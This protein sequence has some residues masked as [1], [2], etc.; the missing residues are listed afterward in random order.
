[1]TTKA[2]TKKK[3]TKTKPKTV[4]IVYSCG[5][6]CKAKAKHQH[7]HH[8]DTVILKAT[9]TSVDITFT[10]GSPFSA[11]TV[12]IAK[13]TTKSETVSGA[14]GTYPYTLACDSCTT[15]ADTP[16]VIVD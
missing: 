15:P 8:G 13:G 10:A 1:M 3:T 4:T 11:T 9:N 14:V 6:L 7:V 2:T 5:P 12:H 16:S